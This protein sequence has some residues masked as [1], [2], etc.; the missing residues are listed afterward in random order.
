MLAEHLVCLDSRPAKATE[1][2][3]GAGGWVGA[4][5]F[6]LPKI[7]WTWTK[8]GRREGCSSSD[9]SQGNPSGVA[10]FLSRTHLGNGTGDVARM[11]E[12]VGVL[13]KVGYSLLRK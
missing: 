11:Q 4:R 1:A 3:S 12:I 9:R 5:G 13:I 2:G 10:P 6:A 7:C 8:I